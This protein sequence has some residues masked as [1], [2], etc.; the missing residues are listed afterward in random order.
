[1][2]CAMPQYL[3][4]SDNN[5]NDIYGPSILSYVSILSSSTTLTGNCWRSFVG[6]EVA[7]AKVLSVASQSF[8]LGEGM[9]GQIDELSHNSPCFLCLYFAPFLRYSC[10]PQNSPEIPLLSWTTFTGKNWGKQP[11][12]RNGACTLV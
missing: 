11:Y 6:L 2:A 8:Y 12:L 7:S 10:L 1:M 5:T 4:T 9:I 3:R